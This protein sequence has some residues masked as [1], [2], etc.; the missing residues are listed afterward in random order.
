V[1]RRRW[2]SFVVLVALGLGGC[3]A[4]PADL[5]EEAGA[6]LQEAVWSVTS[7][8]AQ[9]RLDAAA[10]A[11][12]RVRSELDRAVEADDISVQRYRD[13]DHAL[14]AVEAEIAALRDAGAEEVDPADAAVP[15]EPGDDAAPAPDPVVPPLPVEP[16]PAPA[17]E[18]ADTEAPEGGGNGGNPAGDRGNGAG[19]SGGNP[20]NGVGR[21][22]NRGRGQG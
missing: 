22:G 3:S 20:G 1:V 16:E 11:L 4:S 12:E 9:G 8:A 5:S 18:P 17:D 14:R 19:S 2:T 13:V 6:R 7:A 10:T 21:D 15:D